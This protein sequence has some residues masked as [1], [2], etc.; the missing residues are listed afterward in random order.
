ML[1]GKNLI[2]FYFI[3][4]FFAC[5]YRGLEKCL[6]FYECALSAKPSHPV[7]NSYTDKKNERDKKK[8][9]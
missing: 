4:E 2:I 6:L 5:L 9:D 8:N 7:G 1:G 3:E